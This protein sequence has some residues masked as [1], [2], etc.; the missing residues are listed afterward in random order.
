MESGNRQIIVIGAGLAGLLTA[1]YLKEQGKDVLVLE[2]D[3]AASGQTERTTA[4]I[5]S[6]HGLKYSKL[7]KDVGM[8][9]ARLYAR[10]N[11]AAIREYES[12]V[13]KL[14]INCQFQRVP[15]YLYSLQDAEVLKEEA[16]AAALLGIDASFTTETELS[17][18]VAGAVCFANQ[19][20]FLPPEFVRVISSG[21]TILE[22]TKV[23][24]VRGHKVI[25][26]RGV[27][28]ADKIVV[29]TH[30]PIIN[31]PGF[32]FLRQHQER[33]Y[34]LALSGC[35]RINGMYYGIDPGGYSFRQA[36]D[37]LLF[38]GGSARTG[39]KRDGQLTQAL[40]KAAKEC[41][42]ECR[43][44]A[45]W[46]AQD[47]MPHDGIPF[48]GQ[49]SVFTPDLYVITGFQKW[50]MTSSMIAAMILRDELSGIENPYAKVFSPQRLHFKAAIGP[51]LHDVKVS[52]S[53]MA[54]GLLHRPLR[55]AASLSCGEGGIVTVKGKRYACYRDEEGKLHQISPR[56]PHMGC[57][58]AWNGDEKS[59]DCPCHGSRFTIDGE[60]LDNPSKRDDRK[61]EFEG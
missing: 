33:S 43:V 16:R 14:K 34:V 50:G 51:L 5:T 12:L 57:E 38:G 30:Y 9:A 45:C 20:Q 10:F 55:S 47:C 4:K 32:Y 59:W 6:Q 40:K 26:E 8:D 56:C 29:A 36:G 39:E 17:F 46:A 54:K 13:R 37:Y 3:T 18:D 22:H 52:V 7:I 35:P 28:T 25:T 61:A 15:A 31:V 48:I 21:L 27:F 60:L 2:A 42:P 49:Y 1:Y 53:G 58:L 19:A 23:T 41:Y 24:A 44:A 11:E